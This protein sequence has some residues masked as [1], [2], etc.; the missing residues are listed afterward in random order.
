MMTRLFKILLLFF[1]TFLSAAIAQ[2]QDIS[3]ELGPDEI[4]LNEAFTITIK[5]EGETLK[6]YDKF[7]DIEGLVKR[8]TSS[9][10]ST[11][12]FNGQVTRSQSITQT[13][14]PEKQGIINIRPFNINVNGKVISSP[15]KSVKV[16]PAKQQ[17]R[18]RRYD[19]F[20]SDPFED[21]FGRRD[22][23]EE[24]VDLKEDAFFALTTD[25]NEVY[26]GEGVNTTLAFYVST[27]NRAPL[28][29]HDLT[30]QLTDILNKIRPN[31][32]WEENFNI[33]NI[34]AEPVNI[35]GKRYSVYK[36]FQAT[37]F[38]L[39]AQD[40]EFP[41]VG[42][43]MIKYKVA[44]NRSFF[45]Q[46]RKESFKTFYSKPKKVKVKPL[47]DHPLKDQVSV[48]NYKLSEKI[49][50]TELNTGESF[51]YEFRVRGIGNISG[52]AEPQISKEEELE[53]YSPNI[54]ENITRGGVSVTG[55]KAFNYY[56]IP[57]EPGEYDLSDYFQFIFFNTATDKY[58][59]LKSRY[60][61]NIKGE[62]MANV[63][64]EQASSDGL[65]Y[66]RIGEV[67]ND[68]QSLKA[69]DVW[70]WVFNIFLIVAFSVSLFFLLKKS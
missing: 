46:N 10:S 11:N 43:E 63:N 66:D 68:L 24:F 54:T 70:K 29:F 5:V 3:I 41:S 55:S 64:I 31:N 51:Q 20:G 35:G 15:G 50:S 45:G 33:E 16:G 59:T 22:E 9:S 12:I 23:P 14:I 57:K 44:K 62:S 19:P 4:A 52:I 34:S 36:I 17:N 67:S 32:V 56:V 26:V 42:L 38:P 25:K 1:I 18:N 7:P 6:S 60:N 2:S 48:G 65:F 37:F 13:Y 58:D 47:P 40:I 27:E 30:N 61:L 49:S 28:Q 21:F 39:G 53:V 8:G 69:T